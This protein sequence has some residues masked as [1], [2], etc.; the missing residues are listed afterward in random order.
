MSIYCVSEIDIVP[1]VIDF[2]FSDMIVH[3]FMFE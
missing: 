1:T 3:F 2:I